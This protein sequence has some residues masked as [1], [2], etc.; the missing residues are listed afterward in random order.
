MI[1]NNFIAIAVLLLLWF[2]LAATSNL[3]L[4]DGQLGVICSE[5]EKRALLSF[6]QG[7]T[8]PANRLSSWSVHQD[9]CQWTGVRCDN[10]TGRVIELHLRNPYDTNNYES[11]KMYKL[12]GKITSSLLELEFLRYLDLSWNDFEGMSIPSFLGSM[13][14]LRSLN[15]STALFEGSIPH[16]LGNLSS[17][18]YLNLGENRLYVDNL[19]WIA[20][21]YSLEYLDMSSVDLHKA[22]DWL[23]VVSMLPSLSELHF[24]NCRLDKMIPPLGCVNFTSLEV[25]E[26]SENFFSCKIPNWLFNL[27]S[28]LSLDLSFNFLHGHIPSSIRN[29]R[30][31]KNL[32]LQDSN[33][34]GQIPDDIGQLKHLEYLFLYMNSL[35]GPIPVSIG[36]LSSLRVMY[37]SRNQLHGTLPK[38][39]G[40]LPNLEILFIGYNTLGG[41]VSEVNFATLSK[42]KALEMSSNSFIF[43]FSSNWFPPF[44]IEYIAMSSCK[45]GPKFPA[46]LRTQTSLKQLD[47]SRSGIS[48]VAPYWFWNLASHM[49]L[50]N[51]SE[52]RING[53]ISTVLLNSSVVEMSSNY[54]KGQLPRL[55]PNVQVLNMANNTLSG[56]ISSFLCRR[57]NRNKNLEVLDMS[58]NNLSGELSNCWMYWQSLT[59]LNLGSNKLSG[60]IPTSMGYLSKLKSLH[61]H[62]NSFFGEIP[63]SL[64]N[65]TVLGLIDLGENEFTGVI[66][67]WMGKRTTL[68]VVRL[69]SNKITGNIPPQICQLSS[70]IVLDFANNSLSG[71]LPKCLSNI[72]AMA[73]ADTS[74]SVYFDALEYTY[75]YGSYIETLW[76]VTKGRDSEYKSILKLVRSIDLSSNGLSGPIPPELSRLHALRFLNLSHN[77]LMGKIPDKIG[78]MTI[79]ESLDLSKNF[80]S[81]EI[82]QSMSNL[83]FLNYLNLSYNNLSGIIPSST[84][85]QSF[86]EASF[87]GNAELCGAPLTKNCTEEEESQSATHVGPDKEE[88]EMFW[89]YIGMGPGF[90]AG[91]WGVCGV[92]FFKRTWRHAYFQ[93]LDAMKDRIYVSTLLQMNWFCKKFKRLG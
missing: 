82:P 37:L 77:Y 74:D 32:Y 2:L 81:G 16:Q 87:I 91:F 36:N 15:L 80:L 7:L 43:N 89:V 64:Q 21:L 13:R 73:V 55:S 11:Y 33:I 48:D 63:S 29:L 40:L 83:T 78:D 47:I 68:M 67:S 76:L 19:G 70:I 90:A 84:Q 14:S 8:D 62:D 69:K 41:I 27:S 4:S 3:S 6:K 88:S 92:L 24:A 75:D 10:V 93:F 38:S 5:N 85:L 20:R 12:G 28:L 18:L 1:M 56:P 23:Q 54:F 79:L 39:I 57:V 22:T 50:V 61:L 34:T 49:E 59:H 71:T 46:W 58:N 35:S 52:N 66:P 72:N 45:M 9:C 51:L 42:L 30:T 53:D 86:G 26:F 44:R 65:C 60:K 31:L 17:L 25:L